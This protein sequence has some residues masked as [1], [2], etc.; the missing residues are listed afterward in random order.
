LVLDYITFPAFGAGIPEDRGA[1][2][3]IEDGLIYMEDIDQPFE[4]FFWL[5]SK[6]AVQEIMV[7]DKIITK[8]SLLPHHKKLILRVERKAFQ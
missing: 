8:G 5:N 3:R 1:S 4:E 7:N 2:C 6:T